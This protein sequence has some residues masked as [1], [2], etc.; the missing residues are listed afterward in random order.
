MMTNTECVANLRNIVKRLE[1]QREATMMSRK[2]S[3]KEQ[4]IELNRLLAEMAAI[5][6]A[7]GAIEQR[8]ELIRQAASSD[9]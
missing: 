8:D 2:L 1:T 6:Y 4:L 3:R 7:I 5:T 9:G